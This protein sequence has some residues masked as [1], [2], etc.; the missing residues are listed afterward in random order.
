M[1]RYRSS[2]KVNLGAFIPLAVL[3]LLLAVGMGALLDQL[4]RWGFYLMVLAPLICSLPVAFAVSGSVAG[5]KCR[6]SWVG[7]VFGLIAGLLIFASY[8][9][10]GMTRDLSG[11]LGTVTFPNPMHLH[12]YTRYRMKAQVIE[13][14]V[15]PDKKTLEPDT[16][17]VV[18][19][20]VFFVAELGAV[21]FICASPGWSRAGN[22][23][24]EG[25]GTWMT[26]SF[27]TFEPGSGNDVLEKI[28]QRQFKELA[29]V[30]RTPF[31]ANKPACLMMLER[32]S[33]C[34]NRG[35]TSG[36]YASIKEAKSL[37]GLSFQVYATSPGKSIVSRMA[38]D[39]S[40]TE[41]LSR[42]ANGGGAS[43]SCPFSSDGAPNAAD[44]RLEAVK[45]AKISLA[46]EGGK[47]LVMRNL[48]INTLYGLLP[49]GIFLAGIGVMATCL[50]RMKDFD[51]ASFNTLLHSTGEATALSV[52]A[53]M[54]LIGV[55]VL[56][57][58]K[59]M[60]AD[61]HFKRLISE[62]FQRRF[63][64]PFNL[65]D[66]ELVEIIPREN[67]RVMLNTAADIGYL[68]IDP[69]RKR[70]CFEGDK[71]RM[72]I[73]GEAISKCE[74]LE[75]RLG[76]DE[77]GAVTSLAG[78]GVLTPDGEREIPFYPGACDGRLGKKK[79]RQLA[80]ELLERIEAISN[81][82]RG[83]EK[84]EAFDPKFGS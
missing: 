76:Q 35:R 78:V 22:A 79:R 56:L 11:L 53:I 45:K 36:G 19:N 80:I 31:Q 62:A 16:G 55:G 50:L 20:W 57:F 67:W 65:H 59:S 81:L 4:F 29:K 14:V 46:P 70:M 7:G 18:M 3:T 69:R 68:H 49:I 74:L 75:F 60:F 84:I 48:L 8:F 58:N 27:A 72:E 10:V 5:G 83:D 43:S 2:G 41:S 52:G 47:V 26:Q 77:S 9:Y 24:C 21:A 61:I 82:K 25:C 73:P 54:T 38:I 15:G 64:A 63:D 12:N 17:D 66:G 34:E 40:G 71:E 6:N 42:L 28:D 32:C 30:P 37:S 33:E 39:A 51:P 13:D 23:F 44:P 1:D